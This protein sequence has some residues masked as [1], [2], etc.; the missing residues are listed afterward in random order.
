MKILQITPR[1]PFPTTD[2]GAVYIFNTTKFLAELGHEITLASFISNKHAQDEGGISEYAKVHTIDGQFSP[3]GFLAALK[4][5]ILRKPITI[6]HRMNRKLM[7]T[8]LKEI[9]TAPDIILLEGLHTAE[10]F[11]DVRLKFPDIPIILRQS[12]VEY[13]LLVR[14]A[15][16]N[17][18]PFIKLFLLDQARLMKKYELAAMSKADAVTAISSYDKAVYLDDLPELDCFVSPAG[19]EIYPFAKKNRKQLSLLAISNWR[20]SPNLEGIKWFLEEIWPLVISQHPKVHLDIVGE[21]LP[22][23]LLKKHGSYNIQYHGFV[24]DLE[25]YRHSA[26]LFIAPLLS[27]SGMKLKVIEGLA[28]G[29]PL[30]TTSIGA[31]GIDIQDKVH[32]MN[33]DSAR[34]F[35]DKI[36]L[37]LTDIALQKKLSE[38][39]IQVIQQNY[40]WLS[41]TKRLESFLQ[42]VIDQKS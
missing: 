18:N 41:I 8:V 4:S 33:A 13:L 11:D 2:G 40:D 1:L 25:P 16:T 26:T 17:S 32:Y 29:L 30:I 9:N 3:Y 31:E 19:S 28:S 35:V 38:N 23:E 37:V 5:S 22:K 10:F 39:A 36:S 42:K 21:G 7:C 24:K 34:E 15:K 14:N 12:N 6:T 20:W 27:G